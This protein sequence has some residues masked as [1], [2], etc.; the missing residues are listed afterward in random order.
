MNVR[1]IQTFCGIVTFQHF[2]DFLKPILD[3]CVHGTP[4]HPFLLLSVKYYDFLG[5][6]VERVLVVF[7][8]F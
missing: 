1:Y 3:V 6:I 5:E 8:T 2:I 7:Y 4:L